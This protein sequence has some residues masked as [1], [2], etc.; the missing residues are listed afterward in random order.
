MQAIPYERYCTE[1]SETVWIHPELPQ[2]Q[3]IGNCAACVSLN[4]LRS[5]VGYWKAMHRKCK[6]REQKLQN[7]IEELKAKLHLR[8]RQLF[9]RKSERKGKKDQDNRQSEKDKEKRK[10]GQQRGSSGHGRRLHDTLPAKDDYIDLPDEEKKC[11]CC[12]LPFEDLSETANSEEVV[13]EV[14]AHRRV[15][16][17]RQY[18]PSC[19]CEVN[20]GIITAPKAA[21]LIPKGSLS[22]SVWV[23]LLLDKFL[24]QCP[25]NRLLTEL[26]YTLGL[27]ISQGTVT[28]GFKY[29]SKLFE[30]LYQEIIIKNVS[31]SRWHA[32]ETR[33]L[34]FE[35]VE[36]KKGNKWY[37][38]VFR[39]QSTVA[40]V[41]DPSR[42]AAVPESHFG[43]DAEGIIVADRYIVYKV[44]AKGGK[45]LIAFCW[46]HVRRD[47]LAVAKD[48]SSQH[49]SWAFDWLNKIA[50]LYHLNKERLELQDNAEAF[51]EADAMLRK[52][53]RR[54]EKE[55]DIQLC[56]EKLHPAC[57]KVLQSLERHWFGLTLFVKYPEVPMDNNEAERRVRN[58]VMGRKS[59]YGSG[60]V[61]SG[62]FAQMM[63]TI[64]QTLLVWDINPHL[65][66]TDFLQYCAECGS[67][68]PDDIASILPWNLTEEQLDRYRN[69][70]TQHADSR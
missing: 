36:G 44:L 67:K 59:Y 50:E 45:L 3:D 34:V 21:K 57:R 52:A 16:K 63:F 42:S 39:S 55:R 56:D 54:M 23:R 49:E 10:R 30:P 20:A 62:A 14:K 18:K 12:G 41:L 7:E 46:A 29:L 43:K 66:L 61:W 24:F 8:E 4:E 26:K 40:Y 65:W 22:V 68:A 27:D 53:V 13:I 11:S 64:L 5:D 37:L 25:T 38:W 58:P 28:G 70:S 60:S 2:L 35:E 6:E 48:W 47:F 33:W 31:E 1:G 32:D 69:S 9:E 17:R 15:I 51:S 19:Q